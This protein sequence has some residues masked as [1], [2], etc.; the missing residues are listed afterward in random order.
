MA[1]QLGHSERFTQAQID[2]GILQTQMTELR[3]GQAAMLE[4]LKDIQA[5]LA[6]A[7]GGW[8]ALM[9][10]GGFGAA[11]GSVATYILQHF[12]FKG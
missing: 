6:E 7:R 1:A 4:Q 5:T 3:Y 10:L 2:I 11:L 9:V 12:P 8:K